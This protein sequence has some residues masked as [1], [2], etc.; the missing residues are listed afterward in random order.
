[1]TESFKIGFGHHPSP[2]RTDITIYKKLF[3]KFFENRYIL[4]HV[5]ELKQ[6]FTQLREIWFSVLQAVL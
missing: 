6:R 3:L 5:T 2:T 4:Q 1:M